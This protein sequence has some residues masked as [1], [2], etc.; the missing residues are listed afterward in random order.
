MTVT[1][2]HEFNSRQQLAE[3]LAAD[4]A[5]RLVPDIEAGQF[6]SLA[7]SG[8]STPKLFLQTL[9]PMLGDMTEMVYFAL[10]DERFVSRTHERSNERMVREYLGLEDHP[11]SEFLSLYTPDV[12]AE[13]AA[14][15]AQ[16]KLLEDDELPFDVL[17]LGMGEDGHTASFFTG[18][19]NLASATNPNTPSLFETI[20]S[21]SLDET[22]I[23]MTLPLIISAQYLVLHIEGAAKRKVFEEALKDGDPDALPLR[24]VLRHPDAKVHVYWA[25]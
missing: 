5:A 17:T 4:V 7:L 24:H 14:L 18:A 11:D 9:G 1:A 15:M 10:V 16:E 25:E 6:S 22:R 3:T 2:F 13:Q 12:S 20:G 23:T 19:E 8:G 21:G